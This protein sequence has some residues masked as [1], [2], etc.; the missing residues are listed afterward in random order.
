MTN[1]EITALL[2]SYRVLYENRYWNEGL[3]LGNDDLFSKDS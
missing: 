1:E 3:P 2:D